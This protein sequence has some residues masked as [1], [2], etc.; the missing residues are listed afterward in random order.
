MFPW[1]GMGVP[2]KKGR[3]LV[4]YNVDAAGNLDQLM[5]HAAC[6]VLLG[7]K[8][9]KSLSLRLELGYN[10]TYIVH[11]GRTPSECNCCPRCSNQQMAVLRRPDVHSTVS[12]LPQGAHYETRFVM[13]QLITVIILT[14]LYGNG[15]KI[16]LPL[17]YP[18]ILSCRLD[19]YCLKKL[20]CRGSLTVVSSTKKLRDEICGGSLILDCFSFFGAEF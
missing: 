20:F 19:C 17:S 13:L 7:D 18:V 10:W 5:E 4:W 2:P 11:Q 15:E 14:S 12:G 8:W 6:P 16:F 1:V 9:G 3:A